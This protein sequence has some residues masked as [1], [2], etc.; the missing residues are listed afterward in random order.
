MSRVA[1]L[2]SSPQVDAWALAGALVVAADSTEE[3]VAAWDR[4]PPDV[5]VVV[6]SAPAAGALGARLEERLTVVLP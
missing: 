5:E 6:V 2:G 3:V 4:L 1:V